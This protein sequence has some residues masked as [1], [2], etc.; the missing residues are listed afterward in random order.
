LGGTNVDKQGL[1]DE[2][3]ANLG[4]LAVVGLD[5]Q[6]SSQQEDLSPLALA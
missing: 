5:T 2:Q 1:A 3:L 4:L 6:Q